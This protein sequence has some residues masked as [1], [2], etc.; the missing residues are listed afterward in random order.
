MKLKDLAK[1]KL[2]S[3]KTLKFD[4]GPF[5]IAV[6]SD[7]QNVYEEIAKIYSEFEV[8]SDEH[9]V[10]FEITL[11]NSHSLIRKFFRKQCFF[12]LGDQEPFTPIPANQA[13][14]MFE[15]GLNWCISSNAHQYLMIHAAVVE[16]NGICVVLP[17]PPGSGKSTLTALLVFSGWRLLSDELTLIETSSGLIQPL[18]RPINLKNQSIS[19][20]K[21]AFPNVAHSNIVKDTHKG[22]VCLFK[23][24]DASVANI[25][26]KSK[27]THIILPK[28]SKNE[29]LSTDPMSQDSAFFE[30]IAN[31]FNY[32]ILGL[33]GFNT[34][35]EFIDGTSSF[36]L[37]YGDNKAALEW[38]EALTL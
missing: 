34:L 38:F 12:Q 30:L 23:A 36:N 37:R 5:S 17:A 15:W 7:F 27:A 10:D 24:P 35:T 9:F 4:V 2:E 25:D 3:G 31:S 29:A 6:K 33:S 32:N 18:A 22:D 8:L 20:I 21:Q 28:F 1:S 16:K 26:Q 19:V 11:R 13:F 14:P